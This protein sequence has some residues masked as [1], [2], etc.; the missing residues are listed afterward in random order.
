MPRS[1]TETV[2]FGRVTLMLHLTWA[3][4]FPSVFGLTKN[5]R[6]TSSCPTF[7][8]LASR[9]RGIVS[10]G[11]FHFCC[12]SVSGVTRSIAAKSFF[13]FRNSVSGHCF[14]SG[15]SQAVPPAVDTGLSSGT[16]KKTAVISAL[17]C[18]VTEDC[19]ETP[20]PARPEAAAAAERR[21]FAKA[22]RAAAG[23]RPSREG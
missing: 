11:V 18:R 6:M 12:Q 23:H 14:R 22:A 8:L 13:V 2:L 4:L 7:R 21:G 3:L 1:C 15:P 5:V 19:P 9:K 10:G 17:A 20:A 16:N